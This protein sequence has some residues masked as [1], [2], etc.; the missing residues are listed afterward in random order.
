MRLVKFIPHIFTMLFYDRDVSNRNLRK[1][2]MVWTVNN[3]CWACTCG[4]VLLFVTE[5]N[6]HPQEDNFLRVALC[7]MVL[8]YFGNMLVHKKVQI[9]FCAIFYTFF[10]ILDVPYWLGAC[11]SGSS[12]ARRITTFPLHRSFL[13]MFS[14]NKGDGCSVGRR[15]CNSKKNVASLVS[16]NW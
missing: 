1:I 5:S 6:Q 8:F 2:L 10:F 7:I 14:N 16:L 3:T 9:N 15:T 4:E 11:R 12:S 13:P